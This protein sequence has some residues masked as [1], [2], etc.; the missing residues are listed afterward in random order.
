MRVQGRGL[1]VGI[2]EKMRGPCTS[3]KERAFRHDVHHWA[4]YQKDDDYGPNVTPNAPHGAMMPGATAAAAAQ[5]GEEEH[6]LAA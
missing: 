3:G 6:R 4:T 2:L 1:K 5:E